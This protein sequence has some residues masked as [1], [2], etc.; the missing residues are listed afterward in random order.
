MDY[1]TP[2]TVTEESSTMDFQNLV[3]KQSPFTTLYEE[4]EVPLIFPEKK[5]SKQRVAGST[6]FVFDC[7]QL[8]STSTVVPVPSCMS[9]VD[10]GVSSPPPPCSLNGSQSMALVKDEP[11]WMDEISSLFTLDNSNDYFW[12]NFKSEV[13]LD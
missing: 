12:Q 11:N 8:N 4:P 3:L 9:C 6:A 10:W 13:G 1:T 7:K 2:V 5:P